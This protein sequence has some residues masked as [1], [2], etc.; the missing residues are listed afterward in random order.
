MNDQMLIFPT[1]FLNVN[2]EFKNQPKVNVPTLRHTHANN[3]RRL[4]FNALENRF[5]YFQEFK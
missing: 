2:F 3:I 1:V 5:F 4:L